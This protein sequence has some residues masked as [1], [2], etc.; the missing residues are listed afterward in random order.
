MVKKMRLSQKILWIT[1]FVVFLSIT[2]IVSV[3]K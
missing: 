1:V 2:V 3:S